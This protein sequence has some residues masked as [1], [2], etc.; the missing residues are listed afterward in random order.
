[1]PVVGL[2]EE[3]PEIEAQDQARQRV[4]G[5]GA[6][7]ILDLLPVI[8]LLIDVRAESAAHQR[9]AASAARA[10]GVAAVVG[11]VSVRVDQLDGGYRTK[12]VAPGLAGIEE[13]G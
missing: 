6:R 7:R 2:M 3:I 10:L 1:M 5:K 13:A 9:L 11:P 4:V 8:V 12:K